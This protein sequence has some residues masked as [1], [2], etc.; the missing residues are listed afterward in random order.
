MK[1]VTIDQVVI[2]NGSLPDL[3]R[4]SFSGCRDYRICHEKDYLNAGTKNSKLATK[5]RKCHYNSNLPISS[6]ELNKKSSIL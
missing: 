4:M 6:K 1:R 3:T 5:S 2:E